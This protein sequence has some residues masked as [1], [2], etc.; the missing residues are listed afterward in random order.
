MQSGEP[1]PRHAGPRRALVHVLLVI[2]AAVAVPGALA[3]AKDDPAPP[4]A[5]T[6]APSDP[7]PTP[8]PAPP[9]AP[10]PSTSVAPKPAPKPKAASV[11]THPWHPTATP[12]R[13]QPRPNPAQTQQTTRRYTHA[14]ATT[15][16]A[17]VLPART[18]T[19]TRKHI[20]RS[21]HV[22][23]S[24]AKPAA[25]KARR[26]HAK[27]KARAA[28]HRPKK[29]KPT[30]TS[31]PRTL[32]PQSQ[33]SDKLSLP[34]PAPVGNGS[35]GRGLASFLIVLALVCAIACFTIAL[36]PATYMRWRPAVTFASERQTD[37]TVVGL[38]LLT[39][40]AFIV[41]LSK[42]G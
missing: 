16:H 1:Q 20:V 37:L 24:K 41:I 3:A 12:T 42:G 14:R 23:R 4:P 30:Q 5:T 34:V 18:R 29:P 17:R 6:T 38:A 13:S 22:V 9:V 10:K 35:G 28:V 27:H 40:T 36:V 32:A 33:V 15:Y 31:L 11:P 2:A 25:R 8:D 19:H 26:V 7:E 39:I 21:R